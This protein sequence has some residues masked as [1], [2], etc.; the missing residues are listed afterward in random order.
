MNSILKPFQSEGEPGLEEKIKA[1]VDHF[2]DFYQFYL[3]YRIYF[4]SQICTQIENIALKLREVHIDITTYPLDPKHVE[5]R[6]SPDLLKERKEFWEKARETFND[7]VEALFRNIERE[8]RRLLGV[9]E[10]SEQADS[11]EM[12]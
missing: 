9:E 5:Y 3:G 12:K 10:G 8:F 6:M 7:Q 1:F 4:L 11:H 2:N